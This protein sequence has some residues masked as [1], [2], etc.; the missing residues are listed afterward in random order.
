LIERAKR[1]IDH[2]GLGKYADI[3][4]GCVFR[5]AKS[6]PIY[7]A[8]YRDYLGVVRRF[9]DGLQNF[10]TIG[11]NGLHRYNNQDH[12]MLTGMMAARNVALHERNDVWSVNADQ[13]YH[14]EVRALEAAIRRSFTKLDR[15]AFGLSLGT[16]GGV[17]LCLAT[18][19]LVLKGG[20]VVG[21]TLQLVSQYF[22]AY[23]VTPVGSL[24]GLG[25]GF[26][27][28]FLAGWGFAFLRNTSLF[29]TLAVIRRGAEFQALRRV[30]DYI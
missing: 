10:Q 12:A 6:Y 16:S 25:Y 5:V 17:L 26:L 21:P 27:A 4:Q 14:E 11:R 24:I 23:S 3:E 19:F 13:E 7:D 15:V 2:I 9:I 8:D 29:L 18:L 28:G 30:L 1:E 22:P 20:P